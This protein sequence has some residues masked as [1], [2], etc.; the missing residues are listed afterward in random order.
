MAL[1]VVLTL[2]TP[3]AANDGAIEFSLVHIIFWVLNIQFMS[4]LFVIDGRVKQ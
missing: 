1:E 3:S 4:G 2:E